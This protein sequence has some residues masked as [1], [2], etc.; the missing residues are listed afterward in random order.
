MRLIGIDC[1]NGDNLSQ[2]THCKD[3]QGRSGAK[4][5]RLWQRVH[6]VVAMAT[7]TLELQEC[8]AELRI[9]IDRLRWNHSG[10][11]E[12]WRTGDQDRVQQKVTDTGIRSVGPKQV[13]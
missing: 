9:A 5:T 11:A 13:H 4:P 3:K 12:Q 8:R 1:G 7:V 2:W 6:K 10:N